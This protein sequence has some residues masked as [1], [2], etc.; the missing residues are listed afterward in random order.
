M[1]VSCYKS[2]NLVVARF[3]A[4]RPYSPACDKQGTCLSHSCLLR[5]KHMTLLSSHTQECWLFCACIS[6]P[7][8]CS[9]LPHAP[10][11][12]STL[13]QAICNTCT[14]VH[15]KQ[16]TRSVSFAGNE[17]HLTRL[18]GPSSACCLFS[19][20]SSILAAQLAKPSPRAHM[21][22][23]CTTSWRPAPHWSTAA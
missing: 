13:P 4:G 5:N 8:L 23:T 19:A 22:R 15:E 17:E 16:V 9:A 2:S 21:R 6:I 10:V 14:H 3:S 12:C 11:L 7:F 20:C 18:V 1:V